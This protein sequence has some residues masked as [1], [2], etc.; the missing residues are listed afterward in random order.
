MSTDPCHGVW[1]TE[2][3]DQAEAPLTGASRLLLAKP[4]PSVP[5]PRPA[6]PVPASPTLIST[7]STGTVTT[8]AVALCLGKP[9]IRYSRVRCMLCM[10]GMLLL[11]GIGCLRAHPAASV[12]TC[13]TAAPLRCMPCEEE[14][15][16]SNGHL[17]V[18]VHPLTDLVLYNIASH[19]IKGRL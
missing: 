3:A 1:L 17:A 10:C 2:W 11:C 4:T 9:C 8:L 6:S 5:S 19:R 18:H 7:P 16:S 12:L 15:G 13:T 14:D